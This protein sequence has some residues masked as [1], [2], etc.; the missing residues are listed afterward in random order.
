[1]YIDTHAHFWD[2][3]AFPEQG[4]SFPLANDPTY[5]FLHKTVLPDSFRSAAKGTNVTAAVVVEA[6]ARPDENTWVLNLAA[7]DS[8]IIG[9]VAQ[10]D[11]G[12]NFRDELA[13]LAKN[14][15]LRGVR[16]QPHVLEN[17]LN[18]EMKRN[19]QFL[20]DSGLTL[21][22]LVFKKHIPRVLEM[23]DQVPSLQIVVNH[24]AHMP[25]DGKEIPK[26]WKT[27]YADLGQRSNI[28]MKVSAVTEQHDQP[29]TDTKPYLPLLDCLWGAFGQDRLLYGSNW[30]VV[31]VT[32]LT[33]AQQFNVV[34][35]YFQTKGDDAVQRIFCTNAQR[36]YRLTV[37]D[38]AKEFK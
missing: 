23:A 7:K 6:I 31:E 8:A 30:P 10:V 37:S 24:I 34:F 38:A 1:M 11:Q 32:G 13:A 29:S 18:E 15:C 27:L 20:A 25:I 26:E 19:L 2:P 22:V 14:P 3:E 35:R 16:F 9:Y 33:Y 12:P 36:I 28:A 21:D 5:G 17:E 4:I